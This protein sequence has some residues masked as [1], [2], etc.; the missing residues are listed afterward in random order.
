MSVSL[1]EELTR[2]HRQGT[3]F[4]RRLAYASAVIFVL[5]SGLTGWA[6]YSRFEQTNRNRDTNAAIWHA[7]ICSIE[8]Q[9]LN[10]PFTSNDSKRASVKFFDGLLMDDVHTT[11]CGL[12]LPPTE[13]PR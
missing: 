8:Q 7:V 13:R 9:S 3:R 2:I 12:K 10:D 1:E 4:A 11:G 5:L 6:L